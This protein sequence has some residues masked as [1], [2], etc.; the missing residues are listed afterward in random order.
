M[1]VTGFV[2]NERKDEVKKTLGLDEQLVGQS[3]LDKQK[4]AAENRAEQ[5]RQEQDDGAKKTQAEGLSLYEENKKKFIEFMALLSA[6]YDKTD[7]AMQPGNF[8][9]P[10][11]LQNAAWFAADNPNI[12]PL[13]LVFTRSLKQDAL[14]DDAPEGAVPDTHAFVEAEFNGLKTHFSE[15]AAVALL[16]EGEPLTGEQAFFITS[17]A[18]SNSSLRSAPIAIDGEPQNQYLLY[19]F[20]KNAKVF[21]SDQALEVANESQIKKIDRASRKAAEQ[22][23]NQF[24]KDA[25]LKNQKAHS[26]VFNSVAQDF[27]AARNELLAEYNGNPVKDDAASSEKDATNSEQAP[28]TQPAP[29]ESTVDTFS[30]PYGEILPNYVDLRSVEGDPA[31]DAQ[32]KYVALLNKGVSD[33]DKIWV[34]QLD[35]KIEDHGVTSEE[36]E[37]AK[38]SLAQRDDGTWPGAPEG[39]PKIGS[40]KDQV[41]KGLV[42][43]E[44]KHAILEAQAGV[45]MLE[46]LK[47]I[48][49]GEFDV[50]FKE[51]L[52]DNKY[53]HVGKGFGANDPQELIRA[54]SLDHFAA[55]Y[56]GLSKQGLLT[57]DSNNHQ[58][59]MN[60]AGF[61]LSSAAANLSAAG[62]EQAADDISALADSL[63]QADIA[64][65][66]KG[67]VFYD[68]S[69]V[70][71]DN[72]GIRDTQIHD[73][74]ERMAFVERIDDGTF[75]PGEPVLSGDRPDKPDEKAAADNKTP[76]G[77]KKTVKEQLAEI[78]DPER[79]KHVLS[80]GSLGDIVGVYEM[81]FD[82]NKALT[83]RQN[84]LA[85]GMT[86]YLEQAGDVAEN[87]WSGDEIKKIDFSEH[88]SDITP[89]NMADIIKTESIPAENIEKAGK[90]LRE[91]NVAPQGLMTLRDMV[92]STDMVAHP[93]ERTLNRMKSAANLIVLADNLDH[94]DRVDADVTTEKAL[95]GRADVDKAIDIVAANSA[96]EVDD[97]NL[98]HFAK[99]EHD[100][101][102]SEAMHHLGTIYAALEANGEQAPVLDNE[103][104]V[105]DVLRVN[106]I[107]E[108]RA[109]LTTMKYNKYTSA[110]ILADAMH[111]HEDLMAN[112]NEKGISPEDDSI[113][114]N[115]A[116][117]MSAHFSD[118]NHGALVDKRTDFILS[119]FKPPLLKPVPEHAAR[120]KFQSASKASGTTPDKKQSEQQE[121]KPE[122]DAKKKEAKKAGMN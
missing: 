75:V 122:K 37:G 83:I 34:D 5:L 66:L 114:Q 97:E 61:I 12:Q 16:R 53:A 63:P 8:L 47:A 52:Y 35:A 119:E 91:I 103:V 68:A 32:A 112:L 69:Y 29:I 72:N 88:V 110:G 84:M 117:V 24:V 93:L 108:L 73:A 116:H 18:R 86:R 23:Y 17:A 19:L 20:A 107:K 39:V 81:P 31:G 76:E 111:V 64:K 4:K 13:P 95:D 25:G 28:P 43:K 6:N 106:A 26:Q 1:T 60:E 40:I 51:A 118:G 62:L 113:V 102:K 15:D 74:L 82:Q 109:V 121:Q 48:E 3:E 38:E 21:G 105:A 87:A 85:I 79:F 10:I 14:P 92:N 36:I 2:N 115:F 70:L 101:T 71:D 59:L 98:V 27:G 89:Q 42:S 33:V 46:K 96:L 9:D 67:K 50:D 44:Q 65:T 49:A 80:R 54:Q 41:L 90:V 22:Q 7:K 104:S 120:G 11:F 55:I 77:S 30:K 100:I 94:M 56:G 57:H 78:A 99:L 45:K 58:I